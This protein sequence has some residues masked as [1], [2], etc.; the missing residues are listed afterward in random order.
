[1][2]QLLM[3]GFYCE[4]YRREPLCRVYVNDVLLD[5]FN[6][7]QCNQVQAKK[8]HLDPREGHKQIKNFINNT[9]FL[10]YIEFDDADADALD[11]VL[12]IQNDDNNYAN[13]FMSKYT[14]IVLSHIY[15]ISKKVLENID[16]ITNNFKF[17]QKNWSKYN[18]NII[19]YYAHNRPKII[20][21]FVWHATCNFTGIQPKEYLGEF[22]IGL[23]GYY[24]LKLE[25]KLGFW[26][27]G[28]S[29]CKGKWLKG[30]DSEVKYYY[31][32]YR[33]YE[34]TRNTDQ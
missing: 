5:E 26:C 14:Y 34:N 28:K 12:K 21:N 4:V 32:K 24:Q 25:K 9:P 20:E 13:G 23:S 31:D 30:F 17:S 27:I 3:L 22:R 19:D 2:R 6:I 1:M 11:V 10:K 18:P 7:S 33:Q 29:C 15:L 16:N 8:N